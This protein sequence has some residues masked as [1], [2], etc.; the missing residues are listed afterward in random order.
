[1][2]GLGKQR[3]ARTA[4]FDQTCAALICFRVLHLFATLRRCGAMQRGMRCRAGCSRRRW[5]A[6]LVVKKTKK[7]LKRSHRYVV[8]AAGV[9]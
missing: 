7:R 9:D 1:M 4:Q 3:P 8:N 6:Q 2:T 5:Y